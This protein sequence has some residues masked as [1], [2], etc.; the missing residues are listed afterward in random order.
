PRTRAADRIVG[1]DNAGDT[2]Q[3]RDLGALQAVRVT[4]AIVALVMVLH[5]AEYLVVDAFALFQDIERVLD[6][7]THGAAIRCIQFLFVGG[8][9][10]AR[11]A[12]ITD[13]H[14]QYAGNQVFQHVRGHAQVTAEHG[15]QDGTAN[16][17]VVAV[18]ILVLETCQPDHGIRVAQD[19]GDHGARRL[20]G[21]G[22][23]ERLAFTDLVEKMYQRARHFTMIGRS[24]RHLFLEWCAGGVTDRGELA[25]VTTYGDRHPGL[26]GRGERHRGRRHRANAQAQVDI[27]VLA[28]DA[29]LLDVVLRTDMKPLHRKRGLDPRTIQLR[30]VHAELQILRGNLL[31]LD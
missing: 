11:Q 9:Q 8:Q 10:L 5:H 6:V 21:N 22:Q 28:P 15:G 4:A 12:G 13:I 23:V 19:A 14:H 7:F 27:N 31:N 20:A 18:R 1:I 25:D 26:A 16:T 30:H 17:V 29:Q 2:R 24:G 3:Q